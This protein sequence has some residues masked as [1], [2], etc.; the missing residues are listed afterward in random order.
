MKYT[1]LS[2]KQLSRGTALVSFCMFVFSVGIALAVQRAPDTIPGVVPN[3]APLQPIP[4]GTAPNISNN[5]VQTPESGTPDSATT[6]QQEGQSSGEVLEVMPDTAGFH[7]LPAS[8]SAHAPALIR[9]VF[10]VGVAVLILMVFGWYMWRQ[11]SEHSSIA[12]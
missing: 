4:Q 11:R 12:K 10:V 1:F 7:T 8:E 9:Y 2:I 5:I 6:V 3:Q